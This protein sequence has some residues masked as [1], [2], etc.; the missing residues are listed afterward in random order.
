LVV[1][2]ITR[3]GWYA[4]RLNLIASL[5]WFPVFR[6][7]WLSS[8]RVDETFFVVDKDDDDDDD[9][10]DLMSSF[11]NSFEVFARLGIS[12]LEVILE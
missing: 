2:G 12:L 11:P 3:A 6:L 5:N 1:V 8:P 10:D 4:P 9:D 7:L